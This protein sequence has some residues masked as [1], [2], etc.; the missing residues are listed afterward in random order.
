MK[1]HNHTR[2]ALI[3]N[4]K[5]WRYCWA[6]LPQGNP[7]YYSQVA[8][9]VYNHIKGLVVALAQAKQYLF[10]ARDVLLIHKG[11]WHLDVV[12]KVS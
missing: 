10:K 1:I 2:V 8:K 3:P 12:L 4:N 7:L 5:Y 9:R 11:N 6:W